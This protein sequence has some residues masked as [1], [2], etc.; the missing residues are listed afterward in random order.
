MA[1]ELATFRILVTPDQLM[2]LEQELPTLLAEHKAHLVLY[3]PADTL[4]D[5]TGRILTVDLLS[6]V[7]IDQL[8]KELRQVIGVTDVMTVPPLKE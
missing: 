7:S 4:R 6:L 2:Y 5:F 3:R 8:A 1:L